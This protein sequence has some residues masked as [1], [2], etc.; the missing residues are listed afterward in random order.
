LSIDLDALARIKAFAIVGDR[1]KLRLWLMRC[2]ASKNYA[3]LGFKL[4]ACQ[5]ISCGI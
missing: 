4:K 3:C 2:G 5:A 1:H